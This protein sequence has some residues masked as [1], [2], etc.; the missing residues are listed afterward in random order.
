MVLEF[1]QSKWQHGHHRGK[2]LCSGPWVLSYRPWESVPSNVFTVDLGTLNT[3]DGTDPKVDSVKPEH[4]F[5]PCAF[6]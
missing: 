4:N 3:F 6:V 1:K 2:K 5:F